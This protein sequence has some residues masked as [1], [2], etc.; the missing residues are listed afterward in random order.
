MVGVNK[1][2]P[3][4][5]FFAIMS[6]GLRVLENGMTKTIKAVFDGKTLRPEEPLELAPNTRVRLTI[7]TP[8]P[9]EAPVSFLKTARSLK[10]DGPADWSA[11]LEEYLYGETPKRG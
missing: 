5:N 1:Q 11:N 4:R 6:R 3:A 8:S 2:F 7:E 9:V 10:L